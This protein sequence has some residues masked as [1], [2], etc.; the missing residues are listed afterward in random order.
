MPPSKRP[1]LSLSPA[2]EEFISEAPLETPSRRKASP[3]AAPAPAPLAATATTPAERAPLPPRHRMLSS[4]ELKRRLT[5]FVAPEL[6]ERLDTYLA[7]EERNVSWVLQRAIAR[8]LDGE[9]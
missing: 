3:P 8:W 2:A 9:E 4:G 6:G 5:G 1:T 7:R